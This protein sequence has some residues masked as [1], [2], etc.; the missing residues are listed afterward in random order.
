MH[1]M[2]MKPTAS[3]TFGE[4]AP[5]QS[6]LERYSELFVAMV[7][8]S[9]IGIVQRE[10]SGILP[11]KRLN[12]VEIPGEILMLT[13]QIENDVMSARIE[14]IS[15]MPSTNVD[16]L[17]VADMAGIATMLADLNGD[18]LKTIKRLIRCGSMMIFVFKNK[19][20]L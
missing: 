14:P 9:R 20:G 16:L 13:W 15:Q 3:D 18:R 11:G 5:W 17:L 6:M 2:S 8:G 10:T 4:I 7:N 12:G 19:A 1:P